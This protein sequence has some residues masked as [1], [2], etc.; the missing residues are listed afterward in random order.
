MRTIKVFLGIISLLVLMIMA[1]C[2][3]LVSVEQ[4][5]SNKNYYTLSYPSEY[6]ETKDQVREFMLT[7]AAEVAK[8]RGYRYFDA[9][10][11]TGE[12]Y[13][14]SSYGGGHR[15]VSN[16]IE[17]TMTV[18]LLDNIDGGYYDCL[19]ILNNH[20]FDIKDKLPDP[21]VSPYL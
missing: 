12:H 3:D 18:F 21:S 5:P 13:H 20:N 10:N 14:Y 7:K 1:S 15:Y 6:G 11:P 19:D 16:G 9:T 2:A 8:E 4:A 17:Y